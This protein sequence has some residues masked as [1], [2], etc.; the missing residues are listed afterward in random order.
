MII[1]A[2][3]AS[4]FLLE[5]SGNTTIAMIHRFVQGVQYKGFSMV[6]G[7][8]A[9]IRLLFLSLL[10]IATGLIGCGAPETTLPEPLI[11]TTTQP[12]STLDVTPKPN[13]PITIIH[14]IYDDDGSRDGTAALLYLL[15]RPEITIDAV[16]ISYG[17]A[18]PEIYIQHIGRVLDNVG[19]Q[20]IPLGAG[21]DKPLAGGTPFPDWLRDLSDTFWDFPLPNADRTYPIQNAPELI[22]STIKQSPE[23]VTIFLSGTFTNLAQALRTDPDIKEN[24]AAV[25]FMGGAVYSPGNITNLIPDSN[26]QVAEWNIIADPQAAKEVFEA[27]LDLY[28]IPLDATNQVVHSLAE[29]QPWRLGDEKANFVADL[30]EIMLTDYGFESVEIFDLTAAAI[31]VQPDLCDFQ[32]LYLDVI[33]DAGST[34]GQT[35]VVPEGEPNISVCLEPNVSQVKQHLNE[36]FSGDSIPLENSSIDRIVG[37]WT[38]TVSN[39]GTLM[40]A[41]IIIEETCQQRQVCGR[42]DIPAFSCSGTL[43]WVGMG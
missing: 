18:H 26:N 7:K 24:I 14:L 10:V 5:Y 42:Y 25:Y 29:I 30:Y 36:N 1:P 3:F 33:T 12:T 21:Q 27:G 20:D 32:F 11:R 39:S 6:K 43:T 34:S 35:I 22:V 13:T 40:Q 8:R 31:M 9:S 28:M 17:E 38:G 23:P 19:V 15:G 2:G 41:S 37:T 16:S 4:G